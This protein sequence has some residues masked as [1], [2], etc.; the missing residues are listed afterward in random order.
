[1]LHR[2]KLLLWLAGHLGHLLLGYLF[3][4][5]LTEVNPP[6]IHS[7]RYVLCPSPL[8]PHKALCFGTKINIFLF[9]WMPFKDQSLAT[10]DVELVDSACIPPLILQNCCYQLGKSSH[11]RKFLQQAHGLLQAPGKFF[12]FFLHPASSSV[13]HFL[14]TSLL[15]N[16]KRCKDMVVLLNITL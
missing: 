1:M 13:S 10:T 5:F 14:I 16:S 15:T 2:L 8:S 7:L 9:A 6:K 12:R 3:S 4:I 11:S